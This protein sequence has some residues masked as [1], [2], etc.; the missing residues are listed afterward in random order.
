MNKLDLDT[1]TRA[2][3]GVCDGSNAGVKHNLVLIDIDLRREHESWGEDTGA[4]V[5]A[6]AA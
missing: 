1:L 6:E 4:E 5:E 2:F 3:D